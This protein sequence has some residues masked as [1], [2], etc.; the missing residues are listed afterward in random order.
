MKRNLI[1]CLMVKLSLSLLGRFG[2]NL[3]R[4]PD[5]SGGSKIKQEEVF[6]WNKRFLV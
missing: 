1:G 6:L 2:L 4:W 3:I 5:A